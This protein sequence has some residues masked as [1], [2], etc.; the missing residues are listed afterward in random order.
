MEILNALGKISSGNYYEFLS[1]RIYSTNMK[2]K[3]AALYAIKRSQNQG[4]TVLREMFSQ[5]TAENQALIKHV[6][7]N[8]IKE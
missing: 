2:L 8:R 7:D 1:S 3:R 5:T 4:D 6:L